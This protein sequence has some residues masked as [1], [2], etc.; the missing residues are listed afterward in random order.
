MGYSIRNG[1]FISHL[2]NGREYKF[3]NQE[4]KHAAFEQMTRDDLSVRSAAQQRAE[5]AGVKKTLTDREIAQGNFMPDRRTTI[6]RVADQV[7]QHSKHNP[8]DVAAGEIRRTMDDSPEGET[9]INRLEEKSA[10]WVQE[11][12]GIAP[13]PSG[14]VATAS[15]LRLAA[16]ALKPLS[17]L[18]EDQAQYR[19]RRQRLLDK[20]DEQDA[21]AKA[22]SERAAAVEK[23]AAW[24]TDADTTLFRISTM[25]SVPQ[26]TVNA[27]RAMR[28]KLA[29]L[30]TDGAAWIEFA[31]GVDAQLK[32][33]KAGKIAA[34]NEQIKA[35]EAEKD[36][37][38]NDETPPPNPPEA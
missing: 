26:E 34:R 21:K 36:S 9:I 17:P 15:A 6:E 23:N 22:D 29:N 4:S 31:N 32:E 24:V 38:R 28:D 11:K 13:E 25:A 2:Q 12:A 10:R 8:F 14:P 27:V 37:I 18:P 30:E 1:A 16:D 33:I 20:A 7:S 3:T 19:E 35:I 5:Q